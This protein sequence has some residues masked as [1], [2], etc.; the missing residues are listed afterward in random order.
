M[1]ALFCIFQCIFQ[2]RKRLHHSLFSMGDANAMCKRA[3]RLLC[4]WASGQTVTHAMVR[5]AEE[6][7]ENYI[8]PT[9]GP[10]AFLHGPPRDTGMCRLH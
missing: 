8:Q 7:K 4:F 2:C 1:I 10:Q 6:N 9:Y 3:L 5:E